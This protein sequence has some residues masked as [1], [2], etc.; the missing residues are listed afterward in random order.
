MKPPPISVTED[1]VL[2]RAAMRK[3]VT[4]AAIWTAPTSTRSSLGKKATSAR[5]P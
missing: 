4:A 2:Q 5:V 3:R 1:G